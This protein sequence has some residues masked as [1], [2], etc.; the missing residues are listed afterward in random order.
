[1]WL[2]EQ[3]SF[4]SVGK[5][6]IMGTTSCSLSQM[7]H[8]KWMNKRDTPSLDIKLFKLTQSKNSF[9]RIFFVQVSICIENCQTIGKPKLIKIHRNSKKIFIYSSSERLLLHVH[10][11]A[12]WPSLDPDGLCYSGANSS[13][14]LK[15]QS[16][17]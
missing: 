16:P 13:F 9:T 17:P 3:S 6:H 12:G 5:Q 11:S 14:P 2:I 1:M 4:P 15:H 7:G 10:P 8:H